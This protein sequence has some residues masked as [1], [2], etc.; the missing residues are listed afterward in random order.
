M[1][2]LYKASSVD[3]YRVEYRQGSGSLLGRVNVSSTANSMTYHTSTTSDLQPGTSYQLRV[4]PVNMY[5][6]GPPV[7]ITI[8]TGTLDC[9]SYFIP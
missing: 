7:D 6:D 8:R 1:P 3:Y 2:P 4:V 9:Y 5:G